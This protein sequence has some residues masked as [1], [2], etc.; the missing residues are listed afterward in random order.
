[1]VGHD[2]QEC[3]GWIYNGNAEQREGKRERGKWVGNQKS[4]FYRIWMGRWEE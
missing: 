1:M 3:V 2:K 4:G